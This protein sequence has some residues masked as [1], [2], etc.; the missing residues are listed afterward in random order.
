MKK[1]WVVTSIILL[2]FCIGRNIPL[3][4]F[5]SIVI[6]N[7][8]TL[9][10]GTEKVMGINTNTLNLFS[11]GLS[12]WM[13]VSIFW[14]IFMLLD[15]KANSKFTSRG[16]QTLKILFM[17][18]FG[19]F[20]SYLVIRYSYATVGTLIVSNKVVILAMIILTTSAI[21]LTWLSNINVKYGI[22]G[23]TFVISL[24]ILQSIFQQLSVVNYSIS[25]AIVLIIIIGFCFI[26]IFLQISEI[27]L[28]LSR[29][30]TSS[31]LRSISYLPIPMNGSNGMP[32]MY[33]VV[34]MSLPIY[35]V[36]LM[37]PYL[38]ENI[39]SLELLF[40]NSEFTSGIYYLTLTIMIVFL[41]FMFSIYN[42]NPEEITK[43]L[44]KSGNY[45]VN[46][47]YGKETKQAIY[48]AIHLTIL[49]ETLFNLAVAFLPLFVS[50]FLCSADQSLASL[51]QLS[52]IFISLILISVTDVRQKKEL[53]RRTS[54][55]NF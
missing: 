38:V 15:N 37:K 21:F 11:L 28:P 25:S 46:Y 26:E 44:T 27:R 54:I 52:V 43:N 14:R 42:I 41:T 29:L 23:S 20:Q 16:Q 39:P 1:K 19:F 3:P 13:S 36:D 47:K 48:S 10:S 45:L 22:G 5:S 33:V 32:F 51:G 18:L 9:L 31:H 53:S 49:V 40:K 12:P 24:T 55:I 8:N 35:I 7:K 34:L 4:G 17:S 2:I 30:D 50:L 6:L